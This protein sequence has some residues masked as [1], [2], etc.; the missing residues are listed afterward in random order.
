M[1]SRIHRETQKN[2]VFIVFTFVK[3]RFG[4]CVL[5]ASVSIFGEYHLYE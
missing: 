2:S 3:S 1:Y 4:A 5:N